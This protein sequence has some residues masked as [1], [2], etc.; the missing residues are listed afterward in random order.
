MDVGSTVQ[1]P[2]ERHCRMHPKQ[3]TCSQFS[4]P[5]RG[6]ALDRTFS[7]QI[8]HSRSSST[9]RAVSLTGLSRQAVMWASFWSRSYG[10][11]QNNKHRGHCSPCTLRHTVPYRHFPVIANIH[12][13]SFARLSCCAS[14]GVTRT[15]GFSCVMACLVNALGDIPTNCEY[16]GFFSCSWV[17][18]VA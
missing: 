7:R 4:N 13:S 12:N 18:G 3:N 9:L 5:K 15:V 1:G 10:C 2:E 8:P 16:D 11:R 6:S 14:E 17:A